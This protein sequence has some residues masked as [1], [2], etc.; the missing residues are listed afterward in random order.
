MYI[1]LV[2]KLVLTIKSN[3]WGTQFGL[4]PPIPNYSYSSW[5]MSRNTATA[6]A[7]CT[8]QPFRKASGATEGAAPQM[9]EV[10]MPLSDVSKMEE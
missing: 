7:T 10:N 1:C 6:V 2:L 3:Y 9:A 8:S 4:I 5:V